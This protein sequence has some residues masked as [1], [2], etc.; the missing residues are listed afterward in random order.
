MNPFASNIA[1]TA[2][3]IATGLGAF[4]PRRYR[5]CYCVRPFV[6]DD[7]NDYMNDNKSTDPW[8]TRYLLWPP[9]SDQKID[10]ILI[11][12]AGPDR[13]YFTSDDIRSDK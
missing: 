13:T 11:T 5:C 7:L 10:S 1:V 4:S 9:G 6:V 3:W 12:S 2:V 8:G